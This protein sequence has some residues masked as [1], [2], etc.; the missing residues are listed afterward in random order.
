MNYIRSPVN[1]KPIKLMG[2]AHRK[3]IAKGL[4]SPEGKHVEQTESKQVEVG[5][6][7]TL[8]QVEPKENDT[9]KELV[10]ATT[11]N[12]ISVFKKI[13]ALSTAMSLFRNVEG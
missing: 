13:K 10:K 6:P 5:K 12:A 8:E 4:M 9:V 3:L 2:A 7:L 11:K 1:G